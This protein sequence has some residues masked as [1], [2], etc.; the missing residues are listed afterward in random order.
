M[1]AETM[2][3]WYTIIQNYFQNY[4]EL[5]KMFRRASFIYLYF[6]LRITCSFFSSFHQERERDRQ[7][8][9]DRDRERQTDRE[10]DRQTEIDRER[11]RQI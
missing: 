3:I 5:L 7:T 8:A 6:E 2:H 11:D 9:R 1:N 10:R 4:S